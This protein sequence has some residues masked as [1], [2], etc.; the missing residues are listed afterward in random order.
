[1]KASTLF[2]LTIAVLLGLGAVVGA[3]Y[4]GYFDTKK[5]A[6]PTKEPPQQ[7]LVASQNLFEGVTVTTSQVQ[8]RPLRPNEVKAYEANP[9][10]YMPPL[11]AAAHMRVLDRN[12]PADEPLLKEHFQDQSMPKT[13]AE[14]LDPG[15]R[16]VNISISKDK[17]DGGLLRTG[18]YVDVYLTTT[19]SDATGL[20]G[21]STQTA[22]LARQLKI[23]VKRNNLWTV[24]LPSS[25]DRPVEFTLQANPYR[26]ALIEY[27]KGKGVLTIM[28]SPTPPQVR[29]AA[30]PGGSV[31]PAS[32]SDPQSVEYRD[33]DAR[34]AAFV[35]NDLVV[36]ENDLERIFKLKPLPPP[37]PE[38][39]PVKIVRWSGNKLVGT[40]IFNPDGSAETLS[41][42]IAPNP[43]T[44]NSGMGYGF[45][46]PPSTTPA[47]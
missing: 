46:S 5:A 13:I 28:G 14:R 26:A 41:G 42:V 27:A 10:K 24:M 23:I 33:E 35:N 21:S 12:V 36:G 7:V 9:D 17:A 8:V 38:R 25:D 6:E 1:M 39:L 4:L 32:Y 22:L 3:K 11:T 31:V 18:E 15:M 34:V 47:P 20:V 44:T 29:V 37:T 40:T 30:G 19:I 2:A 43:K 45:H 16:A